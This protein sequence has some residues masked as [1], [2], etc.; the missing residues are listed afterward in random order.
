MLPRTPYIKPTFKLILESAYLI[1]GEFSSRDWAHATYGLK[2]ERAVE[3]RR[4]G[5]PLKII[6][7]E[8]WRQTIGK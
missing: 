8:H 3:V 1:V 5:H 2:I 7:E 6:S 4:K